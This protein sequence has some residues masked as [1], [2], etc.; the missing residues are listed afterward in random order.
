MLLGD[1]ERYLELEF[2]PHGHYLALALRGVR[3]VERKG[4][5]LTYEVTRDGARWEGR[6][7]V[8]RSL[9]PEPVRAVNAFAIHGAGEGRRYLAYS[10]A[11]GAQ[12]DFHRLDAFVPLDALRLEP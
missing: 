7:S 11:G 8:P 5:A 2:G 10:P 1:G 9:L 6:A 3:A 4:M 12:P